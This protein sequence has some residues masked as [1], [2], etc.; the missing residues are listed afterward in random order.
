[1]NDNWLTNLGRLTKQHSPAILSGIAVGGVIVTAILAAR[2]APEAQKKLEELEPHQPSNLEKAEAVWP[3]Y[4][5]AALSGAATVAC[6]IWSNKID[7]R[8]YAALGAAYTI[9]DQG[10]R[11]YKD[12]V[13]AEIGESKERKIRD[14]V[15]VDKMKANPADNKQVIVTGGGEQLCYDDLTGR[16]FRSDIEAI[17]RACNEINATVIKDMYV[18]HN[19][20]YALIGLPDVRIGEELGWNLDH[21]MELI[22]TSHLREE[23]GVPCLA[24]QYKDLPIAQYGKVF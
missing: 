22:F 18:P 15:A 3:Y 23:D 1:M 24:I 7:A 13:L 11:E 9:V 2:A 10:F 17:R 19:D 20:F 16:Y 8:R 6:I 21:L 12:H 14:Q 4:V 5:P